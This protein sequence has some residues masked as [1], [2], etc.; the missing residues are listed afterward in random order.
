LN[1]DEGDEAGKNNSDAMY[2]KKRI[3]ISKY[4]KFIIFELVVYMMYFVIKLAI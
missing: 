3:H 4:S 2:K 1:P